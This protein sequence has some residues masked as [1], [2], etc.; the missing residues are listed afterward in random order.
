[1][2]LS[3]LLSAAGLLIMQ[4]NYSE[5]VRPRAHQKPKVIEEPRNNIIYERVTYKIF[6]KTLINVNYVELDKLISYN[7]I[8]MNF[9]VSIT[10]PVHS[11]YVRGILYHKYQQYQRYLID[12]EGDV[13][14]FVKTGFLSSPFIPMIL[15]NTLTYLEDLEI[16][17]DMEL[18]CPAI[19]TLA[20]AHPCCNISHITIPLLPAGR[21][22][23]DVQFRVVKDGPIQA[24]TQAFFRV[25]DVRVW[26]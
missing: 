26:F 10:Q 13:C 1:M 17:T 11:L 9:S 12:V 15:E 22:R 5:M 19:G 20:L 7:V 3:F 14:Q 23:F 6:N 24:S 4:A 2:N 16:D 25:S 18:A 8:R 21:F